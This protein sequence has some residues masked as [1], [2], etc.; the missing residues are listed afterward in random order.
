MRTII[1]GAASGIGRA[2]ALQFATKTMTDESPAM[3]LVDRDAA[4]LSSIAAEASSGGATVHTFVGDLADPMVPARIVTE[5]VAR[6]GGLD[7]LISNAG[8]IHMKPLV[9]LDADQF[10]WMMNINARATLLLGRA[11]HPHL[12]ASKGAIVATASSAA[13][14]PA[15]PLGAYST[16]KAALVMLIRQMAA[17]W[18]PDG[19]RCN[20]VSPGPT[21]T[22][23]TKASYDDS[24]ARER[25]G[26]EIPLGRVGQPEDLARA[27]HF[28]A[29]PGA[30]FISGVN[31]LVD[32]GLS[33]TLGNSKNS[34]AN[35]IAQ[36]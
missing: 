32:G 4:G 13:E 19:I 3:L 24:E 14:N 22:A 23:M 8:V 26:R 10:D 33:A 2:T 9:D 30:A 31:L 28:L 5:A 36:Q 35:T 20:C 15:V 25:R 27:I 18:G 12:K 7:V 16:S 1:T 11:A 21:H 29:G 17:E 6:L 34:A